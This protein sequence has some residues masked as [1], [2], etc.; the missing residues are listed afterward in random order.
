MARSTPLLKSD[1]LVQSI[2]IAMVLAVVGRLF[3]FARGVLFAR[4]MDPAALGTWA[5]MINAVQVLA[6]VCLLGIPSG[7]SRYVERYRREGRLGDVLVRLGAIMLGAALLLCTVGFRYHEPLGRLLF[8]EASDATLVGLTLVAVFAM[9]AFFA[10]K[11]VLHGMRLF[12]LDS[13]LELIQNIGFFAAAAV[14]FFVWRCDAVANAWAFAGVTLAVAAVLGVYLVRVIP[15]MESHGE[16]E[17]TSKA[18]AWQTLMVYSLATWGAGSIQALWR[19][20]DRYMLL[21]LA[22]LAPEQVLGEIGDYFIASKLGQ[23]LTV[24]AGMLGV[25]LLPHAARRW[26]EGKHAEVDRLIRLT[27]K[28]TALGLTLAGACLVVLKRPALLIVV[29]RVPRGAEM[30]IEPVVVTIIAIALVYVV[31]TYL[32]CR[33]KL[34]VIAGA[35]CLALAGNFAMNAWLIP[36]HGLWGA[37][38]ATAASAALA[39]VATNWSSARH[40]LKLDA[41]TWFACALPTALFLPVPAM[42]AVATVTAGLLLWTERILTAEERGTI[43]R[44]AAG[45]FPGRFAA[46]CPSRY[47]SAPPPGA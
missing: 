37:S 28:L 11:G 21:H 1:T 24:V 13:W 39:V 47:D 7:L 15:R 10:L 29:G 27:A 4:V 45:R 33:E 43:D 9:A 40:G 17:S 8:G 34:W 22:Q 35:W 2:S 14:L 25:V 6:F 18:F 42:L 12:R 31:R 32:L 30:V 26:E 16:G 23:P 44:W 38:M 46:P 36:R 19:Y 3:A 20:L 41:G 5:L